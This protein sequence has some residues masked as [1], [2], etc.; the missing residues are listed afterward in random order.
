MMLQ[1]TM[2]ALQNSMGANIVGV[3]V[4]VG[5]GEQPP[6]WAEAVL[7]TRDRRQAGVTGTPHGL[8][9]VDI[10]YPSHFMLPKEPKGP[11]FLG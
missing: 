6:E 9:L 3:L 5:E 2:P 1:D 8:Y 10:D 4:K 11:F 7:H